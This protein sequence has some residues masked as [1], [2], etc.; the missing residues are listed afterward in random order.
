LINISGIGNETIKDIKRI[1][2]SLEHLKYA[3]SQEKVPLRN[4]VVKKLKNYF[5]L[6][7]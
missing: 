2:S 7:S 6:S 5:G 4:D 3:L 1:Y